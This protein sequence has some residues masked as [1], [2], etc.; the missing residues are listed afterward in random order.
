MRKSDMTRAVIYARYSSDLQRAASIED[1]VRLCKERIK[2]EGW[3]LTATYVD[4]AQSGSHHLR[5]GYQKLLS[6]ARSNSFDLV[7]AEA[8]DRLSRDQEHI[9]ALY[10]QLS[11]ANVRIVTL[12]EG[13]VSE[14]HIG[15]K[16]TMNALFLKDLGA[17]THRGLRGRIEAG[18]SA[19]GI[20]YGYAIPHEH[21]ARGELIR[22]GRVIDQAEAAIVRR[23]FEE[24][25]AGRSPRAIAKDINAQGIPGPHHSAWG[26]ST[27]YGNWRRGTGIL[28]N[29][30]YIGQMV[31]NRQHFLK[32]PQS[33]KRIARPNP[34]SEWIVQEVPELR[35]V[36]N[37]LWERVKACQKDSRASVRRQRGQVRPEKARRPT[38]LLSGLIKCGGCGGGF[39]M[40]SLKHY[41]CSNARNRGTCGILQV[42]RRDVLEASVLAGLKQHLMAPELVKEF[43]SEYHAQLNRMNA[44]VDAEHDA[45]KAELAKVER[46]IRAMVDAIKDGIRTSSMKDEMESLEVR[47][48]ELR[49]ALTQ[50]PAFM[51]RL[52]PNLAEIYRQ[53]VSDLHATLNRDDARTEA[54]GIL[55]G[56]ID[57]VR[58]VPESGELAI[59]LRGDL[60]EILALGN[61]NP[62]RGPAGV[63]VTLVAG[64]GF[65]PST[66]RL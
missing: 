3:R 50:A 63:Q 36:D 19:G 66:F 1:Q 43:I 27:I 14:L 2:R 5:P 58:L 45:K 40:V 4:R 22:G 44:A 23:I 21:D 46:Q 61:K 42:I 33:G 26:P 37:A 6:D 56:L 60:A 57:E 28:N 34:Q 31:W 32:D 25:S 41:G 39:S 64:E 15:L 59:E 62:R 10:K 12:A 53:T 49:A 9:A 20:C 16:G 54:A 51:P 47:R 55:R 11:F 17:K 52:H 48:T 7:V 38:Y 29:E 30:L 35:I 8:L 65:E 13:E 18:R 24:F